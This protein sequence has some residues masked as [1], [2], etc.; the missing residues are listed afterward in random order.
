M[1]TPEELILRHANDVIYHEYDPVAA[2]EYYLRTRE[3]K[4]RK[5]GQMSTTSNRQ[6]S[7]PTQTTAGR[8][9]PA[10]PGGQLKKPPVKALTPQQRRAVIERRVKALKSRLD[11]LKAALA[12]LVKQAKI[13]S[14]VDPADADKDSK[15]DTKTA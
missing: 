8:K 11:E 10:I 3:L 15:K 14:G 13:R 5:P 4:G 12:E 2:R 7:G 1:L 6:T 9:T